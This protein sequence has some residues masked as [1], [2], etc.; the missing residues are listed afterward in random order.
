MM[1]DLELGEWGKVNFLMRMDLKFE[2]R[3]PLLVKNVKLEKW[4]SY[5]DMDSEGR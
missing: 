1:E 3:K 4:T 2:G 5:G